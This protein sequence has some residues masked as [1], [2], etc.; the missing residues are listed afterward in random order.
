MNR[1]MYVAADA[2]A[3][4]EDTRQLVLKHG[5]VWHAKPADERPA[6]ADRLLLA[7][8]EPS[9]VLA[10]LAILE[11]EAAAQ[12]LKTQLDR[13]SPRNPV[14]GEGVWPSVWDD[15]E[16]ARRGKGGSGYKANAARRV[17]V[18]RVVDALDD[19][20]R[21]HDE[22]F[23]AP[24][25]ARFGIRHPGSEVPEVLTVLPKGGVFEGQFAPRLEAG[26]SGA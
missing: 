23:S 4:M 26:M 6:P 20:W 13:V 25:E 14:Y 10:A 9:G 22:V 11:I 3:C 18:A 8:K 16:A 19:V 1:W 12:R 7:F 15:F 5:L 21:R 17:L 24:M 2:R